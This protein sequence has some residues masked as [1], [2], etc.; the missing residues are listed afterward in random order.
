LPTGQI[1]MPDTRHELFFLLDNWSI[2]HSTVAHLQILPLSRAA[3]AQ[4]DPGLALQNLFMKDQGRHLVVVMR[5][6]KR[7]DLARLV[8]VNPRNWCVVCEL[9][10]SVM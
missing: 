2:T 5:A 8:R 4:Q 1:K 9:S 3:L 7:A 10:I 6:H